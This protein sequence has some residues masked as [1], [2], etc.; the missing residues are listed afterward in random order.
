[1]NYNN[2]QFSVDLSC[3]TIQSKFMSHRLSQRELKRLYMEMFVAAVSRCTFMQNTTRSFNEV[4]LSEKKPAFSL[5][6]HY[7]GY[8]IGGGL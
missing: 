7:W 5:F 8:Y 2:L 3:R 6:T 4:E 1:M